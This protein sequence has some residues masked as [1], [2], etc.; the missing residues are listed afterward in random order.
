MNRFALSATGLIAASASAAPVEINVTLDYWAGEAGIQIFDAAS[1]LVASF[2]FDSGGYASGFGFPGISL[3]LANPSA[4]SPYTSGYSLTLTGDFAA[5]D[6]SIILTDSYGDG[7]AWASAMGGVD[8]YGGAASGS[9]I[10]FAS[11]SVASGT[12]S[13]VPAPAGLALLG[14]AGLSRRRRG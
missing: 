11:G 4:S 7:W 13:V 8:G 10:L 9:A 12:F 3:A 5:G 14:L 1:S 6:Y 2:G